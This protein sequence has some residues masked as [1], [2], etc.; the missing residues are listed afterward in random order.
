MKKKIKK[1]MQQLVKQMNEGN[2]KVVDIINLVQNGIIKLDGS[3]GPKYNKY[4]K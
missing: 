4:I 2:I 3:K 1:K